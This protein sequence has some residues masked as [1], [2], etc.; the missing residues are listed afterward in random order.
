MA[1]VIR[2]TTVV[3]DG[4]H[5]GFTDLQ[6]WQGC[7]WV[8]YRKGSAH[9]S[10]ESSAIVAVSSDRARF[11]EVSDLKIAGD[12]RDPKLFPIDHD[13]M[14]LYFPSWHDGPPADNL[15]H[16]ITFSTDGVHWDKPRPILQRNQWL[17][18]IREHDGR[19]YG[20][21]QNVGQRDAEGNRKH[22]LDLFVSKDLLT[23]DPHCRVGTEEEAM[24]ES[25]IHWFEDGEAWLV[26]R[27][28]KDGGR[29]HKLSYFCKAKAP[30]TDWEITEMPVS[31]HAP[32]FV[33]HE[34]ALYCAGRSFP[35]SEGD[36]TF[37]N[38][39]GASLGLWRIEPGRAEPVLRIPAMG[40]CSYPGMI[41]DPEG[42]ICLTYYSQHAYHMGIL[43]S[44]FREEPGIA[45][46][47]PADD[48]YFAELELP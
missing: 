27:S 8:S 23:W 4:M 25:D 35:C 36:S 44:P 47:L 42:R 39:G 20:L 9:I 6:Y 3:R 32:V 24:G 28:A 22:W 17:W 12:N 1:R 46:W 21:V 7:Y 18:R 5:N 33:H 34:G 26:S 11:R 2:Q 15:Q 14:A 41:K 30:Y 19:Y 48:V 40:D 31:I 13:R 45:E 29:D 16:Y 37:L 10:M 43:S 38:G